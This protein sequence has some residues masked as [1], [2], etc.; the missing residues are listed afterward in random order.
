MM[1]VEAFEITQSSLK[2]SQFLNAPRPLGSGLLTLCSE[3]G[4]FVV[5]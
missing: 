4:N 5:W 3:A 2:N 1:L